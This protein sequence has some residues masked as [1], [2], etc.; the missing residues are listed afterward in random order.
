M[1]ED[2]VSCRH[3]LFIPAK[4]APIGI[5]KLNGVRQAKP[6]KGINI[7]DWNKVLVKWEMN[8]VCLNPFEREAVR[9]KF[10]VQINWER[11][12]L[13]LLPANRVLRNPLSVPCRTERGISLLKPDDLQ[14]SERSIPFKLRHC[15]YRGWA[16]DSNDCLFPYLF[17]SQETKE[18]RG[19]SNSLGWLSRERVRQ[20]VK[21]KF[22]FFFLVPLICTIFVDG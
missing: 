4:Q 15:G 10:R 7:I 1:G 3:R 11:S 18:Q 9:L 2:T 5:Y 6:Q 19:P 12:T 22:C 20:K 21:K 14:E 17:Q 13:P 16:A 8:Q